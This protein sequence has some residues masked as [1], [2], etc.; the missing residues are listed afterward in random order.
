MEGLSQT[1]AV[2]VGRFAMRFSTVVSIRSLT[3][4][5][6]H[7]SSSG[8]SGWKRVAKGGS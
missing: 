3:F 5:G 8:N 6:S 7:R 4:T 1:L 2:A